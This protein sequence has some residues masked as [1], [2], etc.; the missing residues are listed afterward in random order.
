MARR[1]EPFFAFLRKYIHG[2]RIVAGLGHLLRDDYLILAV[3]AL[4]V[5]AAGGAAA[6]AFRELIDLVQMGFF[7]FASER[8]ATFAGALPWWHLLLAPTA[9]GLLIGYFI[10]KVMPGG[11]P[12]GVAHVIEAAHLRNG[13][14]P[15]AAGLGA[16]FASAASIGVGAS[17]GREGP[18]VHLGATLGSWLGRKLHLDR[19]MTLSLLGCGVAAAIAASFNA[20]LAGVLFALEVVIGNYAI[21]NFA[22]VVIAGVT[23]TIVSRLRYGDFPA[24]IVPDHAIASFAEFPAFALL[25]VFCAGVAVVFIRA[26]LAANTLAENAPCPR[27]AMPGVAG[28]CVGALACFLPQVLGVGYE[29]TDTAIK[30]MYPLALLLALLAAKLVATVVCIGFGFGGGVFSPSLFMGAMLGGAF[31]LVMIQLFPDLGTSAGAYTLVGM[32]ALA[33]AVLG[34]PISTVLMIFELTGNYP[35]T[36]AV[37]VAVVI[38]TILSSRIV[39]TSFFTCQMEKWGLDLEHGRE[40]Q[41]LDEITAEF[42]MRKDAHRI[43]ESAGMEE[44]RTAILS[45]G[46]QVLFVVDGAGRFIGTITLHDFAHALLDEERLGEEGEDHVTAAHIA[47]E[48]EGI[49]EAGDGLGKALVL[50]ETCDEAQLPVVENLETMRLL[51]SLHARAV[52]VAYSQTV[53]RLRSEDRGH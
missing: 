15:V 37:M 18:V 8:V 12:Q 5:G 30:E 40:S 16:A 43:L 9:G 4:V 34:A 33:G 10:F 19:A 45:G 50:F 11:R 3:L 38:A 44:V 25:G 13:R 24:F 51:G 26:T 7:G 29:A 48:P 17:V 46:A 28:L 27:W 6:I 1:D 2:G 35:L 49:L 20:P 52:M 47:S 23:G 36:I 31:G 22:P 32:G 41:V 42:M 14:M 21:G 39:G 53:R